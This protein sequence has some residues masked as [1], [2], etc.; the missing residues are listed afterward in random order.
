MWEGGTRAPAFIHHPELPTGTV[1]NALVHVT[2]W[3]PTLVS[4]AGGDP[5]TLLGHNIDGVDQWAALRAGQQQGPRTEMLYNIDP[6]ANGGNAAFRWHDK[7]FIGYCHIFLLFRKGKY[8]LITGDLNRETSD[9]IAP[10]EIQQNFNL[11]EK[12]L[13]KKRPIMLFD[14]SR[15]PSENQD[16]SKSHTDIVRDLKKDLW[17]KHFY[18]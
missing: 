14:L 5:G 16:L 10:P 2:D 9:C 13:M 7:N 17:Y 8:K 18:F 6:L 11:T 4:A 15:D 3:L 1:S 12:K